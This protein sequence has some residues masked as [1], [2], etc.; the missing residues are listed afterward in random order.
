MLPNQK[1]NPIMLIQPKQTTKRTSRLHHWKILTPPLHQQIQSALEYL[2]NNFARK[3]VEEAKQKAV[4][5]ESENRDLKKNVEQ[6]E[7]EKNALTSEVADL[8]K[9]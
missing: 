4:T 6:L 8:K 1:I 2:K 5:L 3:E 7:T 9:N